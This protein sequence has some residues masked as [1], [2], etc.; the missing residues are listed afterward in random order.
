MSK[1]QQLEE[2]AAQLVK[3]QEALAAEISALKEAEAKPKRCLSQLPVD[4]L[5]ELAPSTRIAD[6]RRYTAG[7]A[8]GVFYNGSTS[9][10]NIAGI[11]NVGDLP[12]KVVESPTIT[13]WYGGEC[14][15]PDWVKVKV[16]FNERVP[17]SARKPSDWYWG[18]R[19]HT[20]RII[21]YQI[22]GEVE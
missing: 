1:L 3:D 15:L 19:A 14:P 6:Q 7:T 16:Y 4:T 17:S 22:L 2:R 8:G 9:H 11:L 13:P 20:H 12:F 21:G 10:T 18:T 5:V